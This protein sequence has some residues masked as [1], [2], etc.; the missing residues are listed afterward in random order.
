MP[1]DEIWIK[2]GGDH[3]GNSFKICLQVLNVDNPNAKE[4]TNV[5]AC[6]QAKDNHENLT[7]LVKILKEQIE[8]LLLKKG[9]GCLSLVIMPFWLLCMGC[10]GQKVHTVAYGATSSKKNYKFH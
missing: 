5:I 9:S 10:L 6:M 2:I 3:G 8:S 1:K 7:T 4:N